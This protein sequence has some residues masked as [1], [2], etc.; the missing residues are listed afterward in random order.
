VKEL[1]DAYKPTELRLDAL[2][3]TVQDL[4]LAEKVIQKQLG[5]LSATV[6]YTLEN[7]AYR[8]LPELLQRDHKLL[9]QG[10]LKREHI[11]SRDGGFLE[12]NIVGDALQ[13]GKKFKI[14]G[15][16]KAQ[17]SRND[18]DRFIRK[19]LDRFQGMFDPVFALLV[20]H[21]TSDKD[22]ED[23]ARS[24]GIVLYHSYDF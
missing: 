2:I 21:M 7:E 12:V 19:K 18:V 14:I 4:A 10:R 16:S 1:A 20:T 15:E 5:G 6:G 11:Q 23:Y 17:L 3:D 8:H 22:V 24:K 9:V 13:D